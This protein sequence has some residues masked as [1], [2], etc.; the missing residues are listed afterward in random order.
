MFYLINNENGFTPEAYKTEAAARQAAGR[1]A[2][3]G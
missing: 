1:K 2:I 3:A